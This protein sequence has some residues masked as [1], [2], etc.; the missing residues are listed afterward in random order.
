MKTKVTTADLKII[1]IAG[2]IWGMSEV[3]VGT[4]LNGCAVQYSGAVMT[5]L[6]FFYLSFTWTATRK[7]LSLIL[8]LAMVFFFKL[9][10]ALLLSVPITHGS[11]LNPAFA[12]VLQTIA[13]MTLVLVLGQR[14]FKKRN[15][16]LFAGG[17]AALSASL[18]FPFAGYFT[19]S[20]ACLMAGT[21]IPVSV[22]TSPLAAGIALLTTPFGFFVANR[23][24]TFEGITGISK[25]KII[26]QYWPAMVFLF[27]ILLT[28]LKG[29]F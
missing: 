23:L 7:I 12:F 16:R 18:L 15:Y 4:W 3:I 2:A 20:A 28:A 10:N 13:F 5:G 9:F 19:G 21:Q 29:T 22:Y 26:N 6:A 14:F 17:A 8:L 1:L 27:C 11:I 24:K 25:F